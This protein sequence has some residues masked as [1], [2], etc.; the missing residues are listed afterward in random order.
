[1]EGIHALNPDV[2]GHSDEYTNRV[3][4]SVRTR[5]ESGGELL[6]PS[7]IRLMRRLIRDKLYRGRS[8]TETMEFFKSVERGEDL[9]IMP[10]KHRASFDIDTFIAYEPMVY[11]DILLDD[12]HRVSR[13][14]PEYEKYADIEKFLRKLEPLDP[15]N[16]PDNSLVREF[17]G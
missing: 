12:L 13:T 6:H 2:I 14:Y 7:K 4:V 1:M 10:Y 17:I 3:Y 9:Y 15:A 16:V 11:R 5:L 8:I